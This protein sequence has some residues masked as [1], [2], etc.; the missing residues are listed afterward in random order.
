M[1]L[2]DALGGYDDV[3]KP[4][5]W[6]SIRDDLTPVVAAEQEDHTEMVDM[7]GWLCR[8]ETCESYY[9]GQDAPYACVYYPT[10]DEVVQLAWDHE[11]EQPDRMYL[12]SDVVDL[13]EKR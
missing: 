8:K 3:I 10:W 11:W 5:V 9:R 1:N 2:Q 12:L 13:L 4:D 7:E 6:D